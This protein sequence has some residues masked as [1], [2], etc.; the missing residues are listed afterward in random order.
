[1]KVCTRLLAGLTFLLGTVLLL[2]SL[3][4]GVYVWMIKEPVTAKATHV[5]GRVEAALGA[6][7]K[8]LAHV[9]ASLNNAAERLDDAKAKQRQV[10]Q[11]PQRNTL[12]RTLARTALQSMAPD[13]GDAHEKLHTVAEAAVVVN[14]VL[15]DVGNFPFLSASGLDVDGMAAMNRQLAAVGPAAWE[16]SRL[17]GASGPDPDS[18]AAS[19]ELSKIERALEAMH[20]LIAAYEPRLTEVRQRTEGLKSRTLFWITPAT[21]FISFV[22]FWIAL[23]QVSLLFHACSWWKG[24]AC[25]VTPTGPVRPT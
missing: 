20:G 25:A 22:C 2:L 8:G 5:F 9:K 4:G 13:L 21:V 23:S 18:D 12:R 19:A 3:A 11:G 10:A 7:D 24:S 6:A 1:M 15:E 16:M 14:S 17:F